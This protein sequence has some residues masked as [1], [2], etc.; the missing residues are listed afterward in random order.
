MPLDQQDLDM[1]AGLIHKN[2]ASAVNSAQFGG[3]TVSVSPPDLAYLGNRRYVSYATGK[4]YGKADG[5]RLIELGPIP[6]AE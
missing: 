5:G 1:I 3:P 6:D 2:V 4:V